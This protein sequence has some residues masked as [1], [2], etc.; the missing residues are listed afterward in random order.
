MGRIHFLDPPKALGQQEQQLLYAPRRRKGGGEGFEGGGGA[1][2]KKI[3]QDAHKKDPKK[4]ETDRKGVQDQIIDNYSGP[5][6]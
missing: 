2:I 5:L 6:Q 3:P 1:W 4:Q